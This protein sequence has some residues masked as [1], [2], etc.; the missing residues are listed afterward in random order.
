MIRM[1]MIIMSRMIM[2]RMIM[3]MIRMIGFAIYP[4]FGQN[5]ARVTIR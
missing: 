4:K 1:I 5:F 3:F 2:K